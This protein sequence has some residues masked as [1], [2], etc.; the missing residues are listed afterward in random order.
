V[1]KPLKD[2]N[3]ASD[4]GYEFPD[5]ESIRLTEEDIR[6]LDRAKREANQAR[7]MNRKP[8]LVTQWKPIGLMPLPACG[9]GFF[10]RGPIPLDWLTSAC[11]LRGTGFHIAMYGWFLNHVPGNLYDSPTLEDAAL[12]LGRSLGAITRGLHEAQDAGLL[13][14]VREPAGQTTISVQAVLE[15]NPKR[16]PLR[17]PIPLS[18]WLSASRLPGKALQMAAL[19]WCVAYWGYSAQFELAMYDWP[20]FGLS[21]FSACRGLRALEGAGLVSVV[22]R[23]G[24]SPIVTLLDAK[25]AKS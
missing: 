4:N 19:C 10:L 9:S 13:S 24:L 17:G 8:W 5:M 18:W 12:K 11:R 3:N 21:R 22:R 15:K 14:L 25:E 20:E 16:H 6:Q 23:P 2:T 7:R 1:S